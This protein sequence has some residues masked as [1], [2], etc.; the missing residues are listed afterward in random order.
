MGKSLL[1][2]A[3][4]LGSFFF[5]D[6]GLPFAV[7]WTGFVDTGAGISVQAGIPDF[8]SADGLFQSIKRENSKESLSSGKDLF[9]ASVFSV[10]YFEF[11][12]FVYL[13]LLILWFIIIFVAVR[14]DDDVVLPD[15]G[16]P[17]ATFC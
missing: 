15:D 1:A 9:D 11:K 5:I 12:C 8:R 2:D 14:A 13:I 10:R 17:R 7:H 4:I 16:P 6:G 3:W